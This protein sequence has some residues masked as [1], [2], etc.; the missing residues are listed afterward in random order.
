ME[1]AQGP[2]AIMQTFFGIHAASTLAASIRLGVYGALAGGART[3]DEVAAKIGAPVRSTRVLLDAT[4]ALGF[5]TKKG[6]EYALAPHAADHLVPG[7]P[8]YMGDVAN[9]L[10]SP[11]HAAEY[12][13]LDEVVKNGGTMLHAHA[14]TPQ[15]PFWETFAASSAALAFP[16]AQALDGIVGAHL[17]SKPKARVLDIAC[18]SGIY[19]LTL[20]RRP[21]VEV[22]LLDW[23]NVLEKT[24]QWLPRLGADA[25]R[26]KFLPGNLFEA[27]YGGP[28]D[29]V[30]LSHV[31]H[32]FDDAT[33]AGLTRKVAAA[34]ATGG[35]VATQ[36]FVA[37]PEN[38]TAALFA[39]TMLMWTRQG[40][41]YAA[42]DFARWYE[43]AGLGK[44]EV[45]AG[46]GIPTSWMVGV[47]R[48]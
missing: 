6:G 10:L 1:H 17:A 32:H 37:A 42:D 15:H 48:G 43:A 7:K 8:Q 2:G 27:D 3:A 31:Y 38:P 45:Y 19:G 5:L 16:A 40:Q 24:R 36:D 47:K 22:T 25:G 9:I 4:S 30:L 34:T 35:L 23:P 18:G 46:G 13:R 14:E 39:I 12:V 26:V 44:P 28:Y 41:S 11:E 33:C 29:L 21:N 20:A